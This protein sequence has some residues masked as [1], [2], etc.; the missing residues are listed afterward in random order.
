MQTPKSIDSLPDGSDLQQQDWEQLEGADLLAEEDAD[1]ASDAE[2]DG[3]L[4]GEDDDN[5]YQES[6]DALPDDAEEKAIARDPSR[7]GGLFDEI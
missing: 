2:P 1:D 3:E 7:E 6:D 4:D 5:A